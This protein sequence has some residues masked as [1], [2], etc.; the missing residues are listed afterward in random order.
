MPSGFIKSQAELLSQS[1]DPFLV[2]QNLRDKYALSSFPSQMSR[3][4]DVWYSYGDRHGEYQNMYKSG[5]KSL[6]SQDISSKYI[7]QYEQFGRDGI[8]EQIRKSNLARTRGLT[9]SS[10]TDTI[11]SQIRILPEYMKDYR[12]T[13]EDK[14]KNNN[15]ASEGVER[16]SMDCVEVGD[17][18]AL[19]AKCQDI[20]KKLEEDIFVTTAAVAVLCGRRSIEI[21]KLGEFSQGKRGSHSCMFTGFAKKRGNPCDSIE[22]PLLIKYKYVDRCIKHIR[23]KLKL[24]TLSN[25]QI[26]SRYSHKLSDAAKILMETLNVKFHD[27]RSIYG[28]ITYMAFDNTWS[29]NIW[30]KNVL[31]HDNID[32]SIHYSRCKIGDSK[33]KLGEWRQR[34]T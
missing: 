29:I 11:I 4:K 16:R 26:N 20:V 9:G 15:F 12:L 21:L 34:S 27:L 22:I 28:A 32:T 24:E 7:Q 10:R 13:D 2:L 3:V 30:L 33:L 17:P 31:G 1:K 25:S 19:V 6:V 23:S 18:D 14:T 8:K 5:M